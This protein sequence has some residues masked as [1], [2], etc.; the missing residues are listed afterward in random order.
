M[1]VLLS[2]YAIKCIHYCMTDLAV[3]CCKLAKYCT[4]LAIAA[5]LTLK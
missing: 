3:L 2:S 4:Y 5:M 1:A